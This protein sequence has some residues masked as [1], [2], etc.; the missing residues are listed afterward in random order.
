MPNCV[1]ESRPETKPDLEPDCLPAPAAK[2]QKHNMSEDVDAVPAL[3][4]EPPAVLP[5]ES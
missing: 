1:T 2:R 4:G 3:T 5:S